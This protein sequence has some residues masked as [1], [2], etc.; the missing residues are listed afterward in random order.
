MTAKLGIID[1]CSLVTLI[2]YSI[3]INFVGDIKNMFFV[4]SENIISECFGYFNNIHI[5]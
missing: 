2:P 4:A 3:K 5:R 1:I